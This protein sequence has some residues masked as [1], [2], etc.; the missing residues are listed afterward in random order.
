MAIAINASREIMMCLFA[1]R[2]TLTDRSHRDLKSSNA[3]E[4]SWRFWK[5]YTIHR[6][7][8]A[9][10]DLNPALQTRA[11]PSGRALSGLYLRSLVFWD[12][13]S[14]P[15]GSMD[16]FLLSVVYCQV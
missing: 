12:W 9:S 14:N 8:V 7:S 13:G 16:V 4:I 5:H 10:K 1:W 15:A 6:Q 3:P 11:D 2:Y